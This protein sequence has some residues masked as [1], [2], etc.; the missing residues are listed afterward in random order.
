MRTR[1]PGCQDCSRAG[2]VKSWDGI[3]WPPCT[4]PDPNHGGVWVE[5][6][7]LAAGS[8]ATPTYK[9]PA[10]VGDTFYKTLRKLGYQK[11]PEGDYR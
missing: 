3:L 9:A 11:G 4:N 2:W 8:P 7:Q 5:D 10:N 6:Q 1:T